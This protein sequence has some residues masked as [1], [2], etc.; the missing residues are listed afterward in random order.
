MATLVIFVMVIG[1]FF[2]Q[3]FHEFIDI[4]N[5]TKQFFLLAWIRVLK[6][7]RAKARTGNSV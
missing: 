4:Q 7:R 6:T 3:K 1:F 5:E 2:S